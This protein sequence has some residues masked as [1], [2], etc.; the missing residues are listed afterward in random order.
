MHED[1]TAFTIRVVKTLSRKFRKRPL[2]SRAKHRSS[3]LPPSISQ[4]AARKKEAQNTHRFTQNRVFNRFIR[5]EYD[6]DGRIRRFLPMGFLDIKPIFGRFATGGPVK[7]VHPLR[8][9]IPN[10]RAL[11][12]SRRYQHRQNGKRVLPD[13]RAR[14]SYPFLS[15]CVIPYRAPLS[16]TLGVRIRGRGATLRVCLRLRGRVWF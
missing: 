3:S 4:R 13:T 16:S 5:R 2:S 9:I 1:A 6:L 11:F 14:Y 8:A 7:F 12:L 10:T 15:R